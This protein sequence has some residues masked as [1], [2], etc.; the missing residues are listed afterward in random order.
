MKRILLSVI[1]WPLVGVCVAADVIHIT[2]LDEQFIEE[3]KVSGRTE[4]GIMYKTRYDKANLEALYVDVPLKSNGSVCVDIVSIDGKY[5]GYFEHTLTGNDELA[6]GFD[7]SS[8]HK[9]RLANYH[10]DHLVVL[11]QIQ[12]NCADRKKT[13]NYVLSSWG[14]PLREAV[15]VYLNKGGSSVKAM[16]QV[17]NN[18]GKAKKFKCQK[19][20]D[21]R[22]VVY[23]AICTVDDVKQYNLATLRFVTKRMG[24]ILRNGDLKIGAR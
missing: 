17:K 3:V 18:S 23:D 14:F 4:S 6:V 1:L 10:P 13:P 11:A 7:V 5:K 8:K 22:P 9:D 20:K 19:I 21:A 16:L 24:E 12:N 2:K 15:N